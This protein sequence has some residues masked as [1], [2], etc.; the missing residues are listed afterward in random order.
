MSEFYDF[1]NAE[2]EKEYDLIPAGSV[3]QLVMNIRAGGAG[4][5]GWLKQSKSSDAQMLDC[6]F[7]VE[8][9][10]YA[11]R[12]IFQNIIISGGKVDEHGESIGGKIGRSLIRSIIESAKGIDPTDTSEKAQAA[13]RLE[14][15][16]DLIGLVFT[17]RIGIE[18]DK[19]GNYMDKNKIARVLKPGEAGYMCKKAGNAWQETKSPISKPDWA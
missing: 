19:T 9:G 16:Q 6:D 15:F 4:D 8:N 18:K 1:N 17:A 11:G 12:H 7:I 3:L 2:N 10:K 5:S 14:G 13:R